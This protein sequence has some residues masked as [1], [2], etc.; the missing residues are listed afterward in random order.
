[1]SEVICPR[2]PSQSITEPELESTPQS[3]APSFISVTESPPHRSDSSETPKNG[4]PVL[5]I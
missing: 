3:T 2:S 1:M 4:T 5:K